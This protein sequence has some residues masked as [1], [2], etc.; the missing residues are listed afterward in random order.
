MEKYRVKIKKFINDYE[1]DINAF[2]E[3]IPAE[4]VLSTHFAVYG[5]QDNSDEWVTIFYKQRID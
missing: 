1:E 3:N 4:N 5:N 2:L